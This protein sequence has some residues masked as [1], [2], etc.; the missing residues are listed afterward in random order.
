MLLSTLSFVS[1]LAADLEATCARV[2]ALPLPTPAPLTEAEQAALAGCDSEAL[3]YGIGTPADPVKAR[4]CAWLERGEHDGML[5]GE[6]ILMM[7]YANGLGVP[8]GST[9]EAWKAW[10][11]RERVKV[12]EGLLES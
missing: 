9:A 5:R 12:L 6:V 10:A 8:P 7:I 4:Q 3:Y 2:E 11:T 1:A